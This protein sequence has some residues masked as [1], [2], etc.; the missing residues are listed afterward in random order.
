[1]TNPNFP[2]DAVIFDLDGT[3][4]A[5]D[6]FWPDAARLGARRAFRELG[7]ER[8]LPSREDWMGMVG[9]PIEEAFARVFADLEDGPRARV[10]ELCLEEEHSALR[11]GR[12]ALL[13]GAREALEDLSARGVHLGIASNCGREY[14]ASMVQGLGLDRWI[15]EPRCL[16]SPGIADKA[17]MIQDLLWTF[18]VRSAVMVGDRISDRDA[19]WANGLPHVHLARGFAAPGEVAR[20]EGAIDGL[21]ELIP[22][23]LG[24]WSWLEGIAR[25][26]PLDGL[27]V[28]AI[29]GRPASG[30]TLFARDLARRVEAAG[31]PVRVLEANRDGVEELAAERERLAQKIASRGDQE[32]ILV[33]GRALSHPLFAGLADRTLWLDVPEEVLRRRLAG[34]DARGAGPDAVQVAVEGPLANLSRSPRV[35][36]DLEIPADNALGEVP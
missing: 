32:L 23:L 15:R 28:L 19:A 20:C 26:L 17:D 22:R 2:F 13:P 10:L 30:K 33:E 31:R 21:D 36:A 5:T 7:L 18:D 1:M 24:R 9:H 8:E 6:L 11:A 14:L 34:R 25:R 3:L 27:G 12:A 4:V 16:D 35:A 29:A